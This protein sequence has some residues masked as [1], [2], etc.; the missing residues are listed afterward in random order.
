MERFSKGEGESRGESGGMGV[1]RRMKRKRGEGGI[2]GE[3]VGERA[4]VGER[5]RSGRRSRELGGEI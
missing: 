2:R 4:G 5:W 1:W 3:K